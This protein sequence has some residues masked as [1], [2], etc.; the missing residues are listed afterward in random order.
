MT[1]LN[2]WD[3]L[4]LGRVSRGFREIVITPKA[5]T[6]WK[7]SI[8]SV[9]MPPCPDG[10]SEPAYVAFVFDSEYCVRN[11]FL[12]RLPLSSRFPGVWEFPRPPPDPAA[13]N[14][15]LCQVQVQTVS[16]IFW[17][18]VVADHVFIPIAFNG[19]I[20]GLLEGS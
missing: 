15:T 12:S 17:K 11:F 1:Y 9:G 18:R 4:C 20:P 5:A 3:L 19:L 16:V 10:M 2:P 6:L 8:K 7:Q 14:E 13:Q